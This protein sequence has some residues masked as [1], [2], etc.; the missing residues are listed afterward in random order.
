VGSRRISID[1]AVHHGDPC[2]AG[3]RIP[4]HQIV[5]TLANGD[6]IDGLL[7][8]YPS[9]TREDIRAALAYANE[10]PEDDE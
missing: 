10:L 5:K 2:L 4:V 6:T 3:T 9:L 8:E 1:P 7:E